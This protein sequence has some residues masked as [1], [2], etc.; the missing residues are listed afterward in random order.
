MK[1]FYI[2]TYEDSIM[3][4]TKHYLKGGMRKREWKNNGV[5][6]N[7]FKRHCMQ[8]CNYHDENSS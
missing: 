3:K 6:V 1:V 5:V 8:V 4:P 7:L 2:R